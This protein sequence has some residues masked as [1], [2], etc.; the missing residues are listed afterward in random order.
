MSEAKPSIPE[1]N[2][3]RNNVEVCYRYFLAKDEDIEAHLAA[4]MMRLQVLQGWQQN[5]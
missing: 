2:V 3:L 4:V 1:P 5:T